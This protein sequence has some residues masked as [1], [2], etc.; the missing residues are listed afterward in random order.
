MHSKIKF[1]LLVSYLWFVS[2]LPL[3]LSPKHKCILLVF[4]DFDFILLCLVL[5]IGIDFYK[6]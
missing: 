2:I 5:G 1:S 6:L 3:S 4:D